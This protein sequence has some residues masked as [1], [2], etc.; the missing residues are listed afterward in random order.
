MK[1][2]A[3]EKNTMPHTRIRSFRGFCKKGLIYR[4]LKSLCND[5]TLRICLIEV[6]LSIVMATTEYT[7]PIEYVGTD[8]RHRRINQ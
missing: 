3:T 6:N 5:Q 7:E 8:K 4:S 2:Y 1:L